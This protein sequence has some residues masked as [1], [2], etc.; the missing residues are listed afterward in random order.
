M[1]ITPLPTAPSRADPTNFS[2]RA[3]D[4]LT[5]LP[6]FATECNA[7]AVAMTL[8]ATN[9]TSTTSLVIGLGSKSLTVQTAKS[10]VIGMTVK[11]ASTAS[12]TNW[13]IGDVTAY[14]T[15]T[16]ALVVNVLYSGGSGTIASWNVMQSV[17]TTGDATL[18]SINGGQLAGLRNRIINGACNVQQRSALAAPLGTNGLYGGPDRFITSNN[19]GGQFTQSASVITFGGRNKYAIRQTVNTATTAFTTTSYWSGIVQYVE[20]YNCNDLSGKSV[21]LSFVFNTNLTG[22]YSVAIRAAGLT[23]SYVSTFSATANTPSKVSITTTIPSAVLMGADNT[24]QLSVFIGCL[25]QA[26]Y[27]TATLNSWLSGNF[28]SASG[29]TNWAATAGNF[30]ELTELQLEIGSVATPFEQ[31]PYGMELALCQRYYETA[32]Q[33]V[34]MACNATTGTINGNILYKVEKRATPSTVTLSGGTSLQPGSIACTPSTSSLNT[35]S[36]SV[37][38]AATGLTIGSCYSTSV[39]YLS[40]AEL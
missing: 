30:I 29:A 13:M 23:N 28:I 26:T 20:G 36:V 4:F 2:T 9:A 15:G 27:Q 10:Y 39:T 19:A 12:P 40:N 14:T 18:T 35:S 33:S 24:N 5:A 38:S 31:R 32:T 37:N 8:N 25:N 21:T 3:D 16:G 17:A 7:A 11:I 6:T 1:A 22:T 34:V